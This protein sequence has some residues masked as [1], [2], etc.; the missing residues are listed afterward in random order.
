VSRR[1]GADPHR[2]AGDDHGHGRRPDDPIE[3]VC[4]IIAK[5]RE[6]DVK[7]VV[8]DPDSGSNPVDDG[9]LSVL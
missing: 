3:K 6:F 5:G 1:S 4:F 7:D 8:T 2:L 9:M